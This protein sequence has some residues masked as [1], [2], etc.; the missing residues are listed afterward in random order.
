MFYRAYTVVQ[1]VRPISEMTCNDGAL[2]E[3]APPS[4]CRVGNR[5]MYMNCAAINIESSST[6]SIELPSIFRANTFGGSCHTVEVRSSSLPVQ[7]DTWVA[8][9]EFD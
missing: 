8:F 7:T 3:T 2:T 1:Q 9:A 5:E 6:S 4:S